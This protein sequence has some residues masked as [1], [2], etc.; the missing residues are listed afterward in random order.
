[1]PKNNI[2]NSKQP[3]NYQVLI[4]QELY[5]GRQEDEISLV[6][7]FLMLW[8]K[9]IW[10]AGITGIV[11]VLS[12]FYALSLTPVYESKA[13]FLPPHSDDIDLLNLFT[14]NVESESGQQTSYSPESVFALV[15]KNMMLRKYQWGFFEKNN[16]YSVYEQN[17]VGKEN[18]RDVFND[19]F[20]Q[21]MSFKSKDGEATLLFRYTN[22]EE[23]VN[24]LNQFIEYVHQETVNELVS[25]IK[26]KIAYEKQTIEQ[27]ISHLKEN[28]LLSKKEKIQKIREQL[29]IARKLN[30]Q[31]SKLPDGALKLE[32]DKEPPS[33]YLEGSKALQV[34]LNSI[35]KQSIGSLYIPGLRQLQSRLAVLDRLQVES[36]RVR[37]FQIDQA[38]ILPRSPIKPRK[39]LIVMVGFIFGGILSIFIIFMWNFY[40][41]NKELLLK[42]QEL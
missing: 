39:R 28:A 34:K 30:I 29:A 21:D 2:D 40:Q 36:E 27:K 16:L 10:I 20:R 37:L 11:T 33:H 17:S 4:P 26:G 14:V 25:D 24:L 5:G 8:D 35:S 3:A 23:T 38:P 12:I 1:M 42:H 7:I 6:E 9:K 19:T 32:G 22:K 15:T 41:K 18:S 31:D 13:Y